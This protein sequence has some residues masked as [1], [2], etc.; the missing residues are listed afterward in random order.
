MTENMS[1]KNNN[2]R[3]GGYGFWIDKKTS[4][5]SCGYARKLITEKKQ[6]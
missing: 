2:A 4:E 6:R 5:T 1:Q 3:R